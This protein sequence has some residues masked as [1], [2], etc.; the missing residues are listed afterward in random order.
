MVVGNT[1]KLSL[2]CR[3]RKIDGATGAQFLQTL[4]GYIVNPVMI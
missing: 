2:A 1:M 4:R 3:H